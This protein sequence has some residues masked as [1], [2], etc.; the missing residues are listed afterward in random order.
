LF[1]KKITLSAWIMSGSSF[2]V[3]VPIE[4]KSIKAL[5][6]YI[7]IQNI[8]SVYFFV[9]DMKGVPP[10]ISSMIDM[11]ALLEN[12]FFFFILFFLLKIKTLTNNYKHNTFLKTTF[13]FMS[14]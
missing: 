8:V 14:H 7:R 12:T 2:I 9:K 13:T 11:L 3:F 5:S 1:E 10:E 4:I 6:H